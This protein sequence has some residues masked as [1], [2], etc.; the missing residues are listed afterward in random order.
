MI[1]MI[2]ILKL[3]FNLYGFLK[4]YQDDQFVIVFEQ[5]HHIRVIIIFNITMVSS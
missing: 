4:I 1:I 5:S 2:I 3:K